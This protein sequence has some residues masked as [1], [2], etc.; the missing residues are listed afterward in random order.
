MRG[1]LFASYGS[2][3]I[4]GLAVSDAVKLGIIERVDGVQ[5]F[6]VA[7]KSPEG[8]FTAARVLAGKNGAVP[9]M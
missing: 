1:C 2:P 6:A 4:A 7:T 5:I 8:L 9:P 3:P